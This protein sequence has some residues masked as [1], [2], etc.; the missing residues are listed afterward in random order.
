MFNVEDS[1]KYRT[2]DIYSAFNPL[3]Y[4]S[5]LLGTAPYQ[6]KQDQNTKRS[7]IGILWTIVIFSIHALGLLRLP[8]TKSRYVNPGE[9]ISNVSYELL[10]HLSAMI[11]TFLLA[12]QSDHSLPNIIRKIH[13]IDCNIFSHN[14]KINYMYSKA[15]KWTCCLIVYI[16][17]LIT[18]MTFSAKPFVSSML[19]YILYR[20]SKGFSIFCVGVSILQFFATAYFI[21]EKYAM[22]KREL[23]YLQSDKPK[24]CRQNSNK[25]N[26][27]EKGISIIDIQNTNSKNRHNTLSN[28]NRVYSE[29]GQT[30]TE[31]TYTAPG[32][33]PR[34][35][36][37][38]NLG[39]QSKNQL[40]ITSSLG[41]QSM[42]N[43]LHSSISLGQQS[44]KYLH[45]STSLRQ[46]STK[47]LHIC[48]SKILSRRIRQLRIAYSQLQEIIVLLYKNYSIVILFEFTLETVNIITDLY[49]GMYTI[50]TVNV[51]DYLLFTRIAAYYLWNLTFITFP[52]YPCQGI[53]TEIQ[54]ISTTLQKGLLKKWP[55]KEM[56]EQLQLFSWQ[57]RYAKVE[58]TALGFF[59]MNFHTLY[60][61]LGVI[62]SYFL[63]LNQF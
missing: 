16:L 34:L 14:A 60:S 13:N 49:H 42:A 61:L 3:Y 28:S 63:I 24:I 35:H 50:E 44:I 41:Q 15:H 6:L 2:N 37:S 5:K 62:V 51:M 8:I 52:I 36:I 23:I 45:L 7:K 38:N 26:H 29:V 19:L 47:H 1:I 12:L 4:L 25:L 17:I 53:L 39:Q 22:I 32:I 18:I 21:K 30:L 54:Q 31:H 46:H 59:N 10:L 58:L 27:Y 9:I 11:V 40:N 57:I 56:E 43:H 48:Y 20:A 55:S 33:R